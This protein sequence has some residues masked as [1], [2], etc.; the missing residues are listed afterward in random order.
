MINKLSGRINSCRTGKMD[1]KLGKYISR[2]MLKLYA[3]IVHEKADSGYIARGWA[4]GMF[5]GCLI[6]FGLQLLVS[7]PASFILRGSKIGATLGTLLTNHFSVFIIYPLQCYVGNHLIGGDLTWGQTKQAMASVLSEQSF[8]S[9]WALGWDLTI[10]FFVGGAI[11][12]AITTP[13]TYYGVKKLVEAR[14]NRK[15]AK[16]ACAE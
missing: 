15:M 16:K 13:P 10:S 2:K 6:P 5:C 9:L 11:L 1:M 12:T 3:R 8:A 7:I 4:I 14:R